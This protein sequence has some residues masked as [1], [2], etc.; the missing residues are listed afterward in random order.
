VKH[1]PALDGLRAFA[2][3]LVLAVHGL[4]PQFPGAFIGVDVFF[5]LSGYLI[6]A[7]LLDEHDRTGRINIWYFYVR[8]ALR[9]M[10]ALWIMVPVVLLLAAQLDPPD[11]FEN[12]FG[13][14]VG[15]LSYTTNWIWMAENGRRNLFDHTWSL[16]IEEQYYLIWAPL[17]CALLVRMSARGALLLL[18]AAIGCVNLWRLGLFFHGASFWRL[19]LGFDTRAD[20]LLAGAATAFLVSIAGARAWLRA[21]LN[22]VPGAAIAAVGALCVLARFNLNIEGQCIYGP[23][24]SLLTVTIIL[25]ITLR[26]EGI[27]A[28]ALT[29]R[30]A[31]YLGSISY[32]VYLWHDPL[33]HFVENFSERW[34]FRIPVV[35]IVAPIIAAISYRYLE[36]PALAL[37]HRFNEKRGLKKAGA[38]ANWL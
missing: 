10:P 38:A 33:L 24:L 19:Y 32:G 7:S 15:A 3:T 9:L 20:E 4:R 12:D 27:L 1:I 37:K 21:W 36:R 18:I 13:D 25:D 2:I 6:T 23:L 28:G 5:V 26:Q 16:A 14:A 8:R 17:L 31:V 29:L 22:L 30:P 11:F 34:Y 35:F